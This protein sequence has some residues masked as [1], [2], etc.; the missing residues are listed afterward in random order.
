MKRVGV[1][2]AA[3]LVAASCAADG[4]QDGYADRPAAG[5]EADTL[6]AD[7]NERREPVGT[8]VAERL[9]PF[10]DGRTWI[11]A[12]VDGIAI[13]NGPTL[14][15]ADD[16]SSTG[17]EAVIGGCLLGSEY[18]ATVTSDGTLA[19]DENLPLSVYDCGESRTPVA[20]QIVLADVVFGTPSIVLDGYRLLLR[21]ENSEL[22]LRRRAATYD[23]FGEWTVAAIDR[24]RVLNDLVLVFHEPSGGS[25]SEPSAD[26]LSGV[27]ELRL[28]NQLL[29]T[30]SYNGSG[31]SRTI[32]GGYDAFCTD[33]PFVSNGEFESIRDT[34]ASAAALWLVG[35][36]EAQLSDGQHLIDLRRSLTLSPTRAAEVFVLP[37]DLPV[38][39]EYTAAETPTSDSHPTF[40]GSVT[41]SDG[42]E[43]VRISI[44]W[45]T[46]PGW[47]GVD[48]DRAETPPATERGGRVVYIWPD[49]RNIRVPFT[50]ETDV[51]IFFGRPVTEVPSDLIDSL[52][53]SLIEVTSDE[54]LGLVSALSG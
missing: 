19:V 32:E 47:V 13:F 27:A 30:F 36:N 45:T 49:G 16:S 3:L 29:A 12:E 21:T 42:G 10:S 41:A 23:L 26:S 18:A 1:L 35:E 6:P 43:T 22:T 46:R 39:F 11:V 15:A 8:Q 51:S 17:T 24:G 52:I 50:S 7:H 14:A 54:W 48:D 2:L 25:H 38:G 4:P 44:R 40:V 37:D 34:L 28:C 53:A 9:D 33:P 5:R 31:I 20:V